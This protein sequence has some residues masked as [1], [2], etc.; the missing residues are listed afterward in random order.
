MQSAR[1]LI[2]TLPRCGSWNMAVDQALLESANEHGLTTL[3]FYFWEPTLSL[4]YFQNLADRQLHASSLDCPL[5]RRSTGGGA[6]LHDHEIT[7]SLV[8]PSENRWSHQHELLYW[9]VHECVVMLLARYQ[10]AATLHG[11]EGVSVDSLDQKRAEVE[12]HGELPEVV[13]APHSFLCFQRR[14]A[15]DVI[16]RGY[17]VCGSAQRRKKNALLQHG[18]LLLRQSP[19]AP[20]LPGFLDLA[21]RAAHLNVAGFLSDW[22]KSMAEVLDLKMEPS[23]LSELELEQTAQHEEVFRSDVWLSKMR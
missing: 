18:S 9:K 1:L 13:V 19:L 2:D 12:P 7:Y 4:G 20:E 22:S 17:K 21:G 14:T 11:R 23:D 16:T 8:M 10:I 5:V 6:I 3:R 15:G